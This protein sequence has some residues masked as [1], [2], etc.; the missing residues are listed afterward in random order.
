[1]VNHVGI[2]PK[3]TRWMYTAVI[4][5]S[6]SYAS[7]VWWPRVQSIFICLFDKKTAGRK[8]EHV[9]RL[10]CL[11]IRTTPTKTLEI[12]V[13]LE[14]L[15]LFIKQEA[16]LACYRIKVN[17]QWAQTFCGHTKIDIQLATNVPLSKMR[18]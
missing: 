4:R 17:S 9:Q 15:T 8:P 6:L 18:E 2:T 7:L 11:H 3:I 14:P 16:M 12:I 13:G 1:L 5:P 10:A